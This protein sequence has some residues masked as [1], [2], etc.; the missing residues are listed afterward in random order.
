MVVIAGV[1][2]SHWPVSQTSTKSAFISL[3]CFFRKPGSEGEPH[4]SSPSIITETAIGKLAGD[5]L[6]G[7]RR[8]EEG[9]Q[10]TFV[11]LRA[12]G[13]DDLAVGLVGG[14]DAARTAAS[15]TD[16]SG[17]GRLH[18]VVAVE[19]HVRHAR[20]RVSCGRAPTTIGCPVVGT[21][22][23]IETEVAQ[24]RRR[25]SRRLPGSSP[26]KPG[27]SRCFRCAEAGTAAPAPHR[28]SRPASSSTWFSCSPIRVPSQ[29]P[30]G[31][32]SDYEPAGCVKG[33]EE[34]CGANAV[35]LWARLA[36]FEP[37]ERLI[38]HHD[39]DSRL[40]R[41]RRFGR[42]EQTDGGQARAGEPKWVYVFAAGYADGRGQDGGAARR[43]GRQSRRDG[44]A[45]LAGA[46]RLHHHHRSLRR[47]L[48][49]TVA[50]CPD[51]LK[52]QVEKALRADRRRGRRHASAMSKRPL[53]RLGALGRARLHAGH[54]GHDPQ[55]RPQRRDGRRARQAL[56]RRAALPTTAIAAS[57]RCIGDV[58][59]GVDHGVF[60]DILEN[61]KNLNALASDTDLD[62]DDWT[63]IIAELQGRRS[64]DELGEPF[65]QD[66]NE[67]LCGRHRRRVRLLAERARQHLSPP[68]RHPRQLGHGRQRAGDG[69][70]QHGRHSRPPASPSRAIRRPA[71]KELYGE[72]L[73]NAQG[74]DV[75]AGI[76]TP[77][78]L[79]ERAQREA[80][81]RS[82]RSKS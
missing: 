3:P 23:R 25:T 17:I 72:F 66:T 39:D 10:L 21:T 9:H 51:G 4:S 47:L 62:A 1:S 14:D 30:V 56:R 53:L 6:P 71:R 40:A 64:S 68:A 42:G 79:T 75:V 12:A 29:L 61:F 76:R 20:R 8:L 50:S 11:V 22:E 46:A 69:V 59:L 80:E 70:R 43:Q 37:A 78:A 2:L 35:S 52:P 41:S 45:R 34:R 54:D 60:E 74:E 73:L 26:C 44:A 36:P 5:R 81:R 77:Q 48:R 32:Q 19:E 24:A 58:V 67:Q 38:C 16:S 18:V 55:P 15:S 13:N 65:P 31:R 57:S 82:P 33:S 27:R 28:S 7:A 63:E 49:A